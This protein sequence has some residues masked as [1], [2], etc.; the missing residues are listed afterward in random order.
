MLSADAEVNKS[1]SHV[2]VVGWVDELSLPFTS[3]WMT[4]M[5]CKYSKANMTCEAMMEA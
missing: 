5:L 1:V 3:L 2:I 4:C